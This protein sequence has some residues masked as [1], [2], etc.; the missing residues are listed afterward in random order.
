MTENF[1]KLHETELV[2]DSIPILY[3]TFAPELADVRTERNR[4]F[5]FANAFVS[6]PCWEGVETHA[7]V[8]Y[9][10]TCRNLWLKTPEGVQF[11]EYLAQERPTTEQDI[12]RLK[13]QQID[14]VRYER[15][16]KLFRIACYF[17]F[18]ATFSA[19]LSYFLSS[20]VVLATVIG[21]IGGVLA[22]AFANRRTA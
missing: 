9:C 5:P 16:L 14:N 1:C 8:R 7:T 10:P 3:G 20:G 2:E 18:G 11:A 13:A 15:Y 4:T 12:E 21:G 19:F 6:G 22:G 17:V